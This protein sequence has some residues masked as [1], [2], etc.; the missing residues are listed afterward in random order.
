MD[1]PEGLGVV[2][3]AVDSLAEVGRRACLATRTT[4]V[5]NGRSSGSS[6]NARYL[7]PLRPRTRWCKPGTIMT[8]GAV[9]GM[10]CGQEEQGGGWRGRIANCSLLRTPGLTRRTGLLKRWRGFESCRGRSCPPAMMSESDQPIR[11]SGRFR[12][13][14]SPDVVL[15]GPKSSNRWQSAP[16]PQRRPIIEADDG[17]DSPAGSS[18][19]PT[20]SAAYVSG[21]PVAPLPGSA[22]V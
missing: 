12:N 18:P 7:P 22:L 19:P 5:A 15:Q 20:S 3:A 13:S 17:P 9:R 2:S 10:N 1:D 16:V 6:S 4:F 11:H 8:H 14:V 21:A